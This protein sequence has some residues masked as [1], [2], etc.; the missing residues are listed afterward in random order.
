MN[1]M[2]EQRLCITSL[3]LSHQAFWKWTE[4]GG[5]VAEFLLF[6]ISENDSL[7][8]I[9]WRAVEMRR[10][11]MLKNKGEERLFAA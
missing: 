6:L 5:G 1:K 3:A 10:Q 9:E 7:V 4:K 8:R 2:I 11:I